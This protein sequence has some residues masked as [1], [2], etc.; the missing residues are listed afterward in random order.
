MHAQ[1]NSI[2]PGCK[3]GAIA[4]TSEDRILPQ[5]RRQ[6]LKLLAQC[7]AHVRVESGS[8][9]NW[10]PIIV[11]CSDADKRHARDQKSQLGKLGC[12]TKVIMRYGLHAADFNQDTMKRFPATYEVPQSKQPLRA[13]R[14]RETSMKQRVCNAID[15]TKCLD[16]T[17]YLSSLK[18]TARSPS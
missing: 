3:C 12:V 8:G 9:A 1:F 2:D 4:Y 7:V 15:K 10:P 11:C 14:V 18:C 16:Y 17:V 13:N 6:S 5:R